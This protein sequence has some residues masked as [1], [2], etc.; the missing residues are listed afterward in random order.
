MSPEEAVWYICV[1]LPALILRTKLWRFMA[2]CLITHLKGGHG[3]IWN[4]GRKTSD[5][6][7]LKALQE[8]LLR[9]HFFYHQSHND[10]S[11]IELGSAQ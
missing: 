6:K 2:G 4:I 8:N 1:V 7:N 3:Y 9:C 11:K 5:S 10:C